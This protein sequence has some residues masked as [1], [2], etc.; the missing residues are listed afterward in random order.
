MKNSLNTKKIWGLKDYSIDAI[1]HNHVKELNSNGLFRKYT[2]EPIPKIYWP[3]VPMPV[4]DEQEKGEKEEKKKIVKREMLLSKKYKFLI[5]TIIKRV[6]NNDNSIAYL[7]SSILQNV[8]GKDYKDMLYNLC[9]MRILDSDG[10]YLLSKKNTAI[11][12]H[13]T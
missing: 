11:I 10:Y 4:Y 8:F 9:M 7:H 3:N 2:P 12:F 5:H 6:L 1:V 13:Q